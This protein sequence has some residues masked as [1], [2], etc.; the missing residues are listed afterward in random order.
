[1][2]PSTV[3]IIAALV[4]FALAAISIPCPVNLVGLGLACYMGALLVSR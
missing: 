4:C 2:A 1:M 3:L